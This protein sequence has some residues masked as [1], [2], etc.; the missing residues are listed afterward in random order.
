MLHTHRIRWLRKVLADGLIPGILI[1]EE[2][3]ERKWQEAERKWIAWYRAIEGDDLTNG[4]DGGDGLCNPTVATRR[5]MSHSHTGLRHLP[6]TRQKI[7]ENHRGYNSEETRQKI[8]DAHRGRSHGPEVRARMSEA[9]IGHKQPQSQIEKR[10]AKLIGQIRSG[11]SLENIRNSR[12]KT[13]KQRVE[14]ATRIIQ[15]LAQWKSLRAIS[16]ETG[17]TKATIHWIR[18]GKFYKDLPRPWL[19]VGQKTNDAHGD[20][21]TK[22]SQVNGQSKIESCQVM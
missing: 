16:R 1:L 20:G 6:E 14:T 11:T 3:S 18:H 15:L 5:R 8:G 7:S 9:H 2:V 10:R 22:S 21:L 17:I 12:G 13:A 19:L 4:T